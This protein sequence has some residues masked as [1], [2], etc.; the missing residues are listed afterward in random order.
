MSCS[1][2][3][4]VRCRTLVKSLIMEVT[5]RA[6][7]LQ[8]NHFLDVLSRVPLVIPLLKASA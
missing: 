2:D 6:F 7:G 4:D 1:R 3:N 5:R 8:A